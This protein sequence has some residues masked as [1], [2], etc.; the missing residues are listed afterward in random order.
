MKYVTRE[1]TKGVSRIIVPPSLEEILQPNFDYEKYIENYLNMEIDY[2]KLEELYYN[3]S[4]NNEPVDPNIQK[5]YE[6]FEN[7]IIVVQFEYE[8]D[9]THK[10]ICNKKMK[11]IAQKYYETLQNLINFKL[12]KENEFKKLTIKREELVNVLKQMLKVKE[13]VESNALNRL[14]SFINREIPLGKLYIYDLTKLQTTEL[15][16]KHYKVLARYKLYVFANLLDTDGIY[17][18]P[19][20][21]LNIKGKKQ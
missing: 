19:I 12:Q 15:Y 21:N 13:N 18:K 9:P 11:A 7:D 17:Y 16:R 3:I 5:L 2:K 20:E 6:D 4:E 1:I 10:D 14:N 8:K